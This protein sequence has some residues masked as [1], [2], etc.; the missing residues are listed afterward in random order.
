MMVM[1][2]VMVVVEVMVGEIYIN[3]SKSYTCIL[4]S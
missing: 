2:Q 1:V 3:N 4:N